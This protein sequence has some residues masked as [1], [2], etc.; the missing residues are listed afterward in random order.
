MK[1]STVS[2]MQNLD[3]TAMRQYGIEGSLLME[4][5][6][7]AVYQVLMEITGIADKRFLIFCGGGNN[8][9]DGFVVARKILSMGGKPEVILLSEPDRYR[10]AAKMN[11]E[12]MKNLPV[13]V[14][15]AK[16]IPLDTSLAHTDIVLD[17]IFGTGLDR[18]VEGIYKEVIEAVNHGREKWGFPVFSVD[19][20]SGI[21]GDTGQIMGSAIRADHTITFGLPKQ[22][23]LL[24]PGFFCCGKIHVSH[25]SFPPEMYKDNVSCEINPLLPL[26]PRAVTGHKGEFGRVLFIGGASGYLGAPHFASLSFLKS[27]GGY[28]YLAAPRSITPFLAMKG[29]EVVYLPQEETPEGSIAERAKEGLL[30][31][32]G[33]MDFAVIG[34]GLSLAMETRRMVRDFVREAE[35]PVLIDGDGIT[36]I[37]EDLSC[38][39]RRKADTIL[40]P[41]MG[42]MAR[43][44]KTPAKEIMED[45]IPLLRQT[46]MDTR[47]IIVLKG[48]HS[49]IGHPEGLVRMN[50][51]G[52]SGMATAGSGDVLTGAVPAIFCL[53]MPI[54]DAV[55]MGVFLHGAAGDMAALEKGEDGI[56]SGDIMEFLPKALC[57]MRNRFSRYPELREKYQG[58]RVL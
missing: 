6:G 46:A 13:P 16:E 58:V 1:I 41:H 2:G 25:I 54:Y 22:G 3:R 26:P 42:E 48:A 12:I 9:G 18:P 27:G 17:A 8:G 14:K 24:Y 11:Y 40:T 49:M 35:I 57:S 51:S 15:H 30:E 34:P 33:K 31:H 4:N 50:L 53:G 36:A 21:N 55:S 32:S 29:S 5:A 37:S 10:D 47:A 19:I 56:L 28:A 23:N 39:M 45:P 52:N 44:T 38:V 43:L 20:P 7:L